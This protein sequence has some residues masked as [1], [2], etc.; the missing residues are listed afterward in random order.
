MAR[1]AS[2]TNAV[3]LAGLVSAVLFGLAGPSLAA[4]DDCAAFPKVPWW[5]NLSHQ[6]IGQLVEKRYGGD[7]TA[8]IR[9]WERNLHT[10][11]KI[12]RNK[13]KAAISTP[14]LK[15]KRQ[16]LGGKELDKYIKNVSARLS[17]MRC[18]ANQ[19]E[20]KTKGKKVAPDGHAAN[21]REQSAAAG[22]R[23]AGRLGCNNCH[24]ESGT[25]TLP[26]YPNLARQSEL[27]LIK[28]LKEF[29]GVATKGGGTPGAAR[30]HRQPDPV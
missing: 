12:R 7:W 21:L 9:I 10:F 28:Q 11:R 8:Y 1:I 16:L 22:K 5:G 24:G 19:A 20:A 17:V 27:Y 25:S 23:L 4:T 29:Q 3:L 15:N 2:K 13:S 14:A 30:R 6:S 18:L 26:R